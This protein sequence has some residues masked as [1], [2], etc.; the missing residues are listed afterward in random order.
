MGYSIRYKNGDIN[1]RKFINTLDYSLDLI[2]LREVYEKVYRRTNFTFKQDKKEYTQRVINVTFKYSVKTFNRIR[3]NLYIK[4]G[5]SIDD[6]ELK[7]CV[8]IKDN[9]LIAIEVNKEVNNSIDNELLGKEF[10]FE[11]GVYKAKSNIKTL[12]SIAE[13]RKILYRDGFYCDGIK[14]IRFKRSSG[15]SRVGKCLFIDEKLYYKM[16][17]WELCGIKIPKD[18]EVD[19]AALE[20]YI[21]LTLSSI[22]DTV[23]I[24][25]ENI[26]VI[27]DYDS[28]FRDDVIVTTIEDGW[29]KSYQDSVEISNSI[30]DGQSLLDSS[31][32]GKYSNYGMLLLRNR[33]FKSCCFNTNIQQFFQD[34]NITKVEQ[35]NGFTLAKD[36]RDIKLI[37][38][39]N[40]IKYLKFGTLQEWLKRLDPLFG[41]VK[42]EKPTHNFDGRL[43][44]T[45]Y[46]LLNSLQLTHEEVKELL[47]PSLD[48]IEKL[49]TDPT[50]LRYHIKS[51]NE[52]LNEKAPLNSKN[53]IVYKMIGINNKFCET[54][55]YHDFRNDLIKAYLKNLRRGHVL[56][57]GNYSTLCGNPVEML[58]FSIKKDDGT[59]YFNG[60]SKL[61]IGNIHTKRFEYNKVVLGSRSPHVTMGNVWL[62]RNV[63][64]E[65]IDKYFNFTN[66]IVCV[67]SIGENLL[68]RLNGAD[69]D[70]DTVLL[71]DN[72]ILIKAAQ[73]NYDKF[74]VPTSLVTAR[75]IK[76][77]YTYK[78]LADLDNKTGVNKIGEI[79][80]LSQELNTKLWDKINSGGS[81]EDVTDIYNDIS[82]LTVMSCIEID[83]AKK[84]CEV[85]NVAEMK[86]IKQKYDISDSKG[87]VIKPYF[88]GFLARYKGYYNKE[89]KNYKA[90]DTTMDYVQKCINAFRSPSLKN[91]FIPFSNIVSFKNYNISKVNYYQV[92][93]VINLIRDTKKEIIEIWNNNDL[94]SAT[95]YKF[96]C[97]VRQKCVEYIDSLKF[98]KDTMYW[99]LTAIEKK[100]Y[101]DISKLMFNILFGKPNKTFFK[102]INENKEKLDVLEEDV[103]GDID[104]Y[105]I[106]FKKVKPT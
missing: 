77:K 41:V 40:S 2:K 79:I 8:C 13:L 46:Q 47:R 95:K 81:F 23:E 54:K 87:R 4:F 70:S 27:D 76:R 65:E 90:H 82:K 31:M 39:P 43:I 94:D 57:N 66:E 98:N 28:V 63:E 62:P 84:E 10:Y 55:L 60:K 7:D 1:T 16:H 35:L 100:E 58:E 34:Y 42:H 14:Y 19:L 89:R 20:S 30:W 91:D 12:Y 29:L 50:V 103:N 64:N 9:Q 45:H 52:E 15:S 86:R 6:I 5:Y 92:E 102:L 67:N 74:K 37:T 22:I 78:E 21:S 106:K 33:F 99:I 17:K 44:Q 88:F 53:D 93:R 49:K 18:K 69:F 48:Y 73:R 59:P 68:E 11:N 32:F 80:N 24:N 56:V 51:P 71:T 104:L 3:S 72:P 83:K 38:T 36:I 85:N 26:L 96:T 61:G 101:S 105:G 75:K 25:S 97:S